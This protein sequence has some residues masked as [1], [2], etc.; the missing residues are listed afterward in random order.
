MK[1][2]FQ[3]QPSPIFLRDNPNVYCKPIIYNMSPD[4]EQIQQP[5]PLDSPTSKE[6]VK[7]KNIE[8]MNTPASP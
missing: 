3:V 4:I 7:I 1:G 5:N 2:R 8:P 6:H